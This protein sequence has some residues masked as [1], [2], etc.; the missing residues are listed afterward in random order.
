MG[1]GFLLISDHPARVPGPTLVVEGGAMRASYASGVLESFQEAGVAPSA[2]YGTSAGAVL[3]AWYAAGLAHLGAKTWEHVGDRRIMSYRR[4]LTRAGPLIDFRYLY[5]TLYPEHFGMDIERLRAARFPVYASICDAQTGEARYIDL[6][7]TDDPLAVFHATSAIPLVAEAPVT[8]EG[9]Q[10]VDGGVADP[11]PLRRAI[12]DG[13]T[14]IILVMNRPPGERPPE[15]RFLADLVGRRFPR[16]A[17]LA[18]RHH[19]LHNDAVRLAEHPPEGVRVRVVRP[20]VEPG[21]T[22]FT[23]DVRRIRAAIDMGR[24]DGARA[25]SAWGLAPIPPA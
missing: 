20:G 10:Y 25:A 6:R 23:R 11:I 19:D 21:V 9:R 4:G 3:G 18:R 13:A 2:L 24:R 16:L 8:I 15:P 14:D 17:P 12:D 1:T 7:T 5:G 22:R